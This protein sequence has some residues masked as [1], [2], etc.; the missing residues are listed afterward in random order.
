[1]AILLM[2][3]IQLSFFSSVKTDIVD[4]VPQT[5]PVCYSIKD[6]YEAVQ[7]ATLYE[8]SIS[9]Q[10]IQEYTST[11]VTR[12]QALQDGIQGKILEKRVSKILTIIFPIFD[13]TK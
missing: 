9:S 10:R 3:R 11:L 5:T 2:K 1:M 7:F 8:G 12:L 4:I 13:I 6:F